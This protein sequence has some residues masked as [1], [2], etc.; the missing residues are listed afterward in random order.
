MLFY[1]KEFYPILIKSNHAFPVIWKIGIGCSLPL[2]L[3]V[4][5]LPLNFFLKDLLYF[6]EIRLLSGHQHVST[7]VLLDYGL[8]D[9]KIHPV[10]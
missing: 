8:N 3:M 5:L 2:T 10:L 4:Q 6:L 1:T 9:V 7:I